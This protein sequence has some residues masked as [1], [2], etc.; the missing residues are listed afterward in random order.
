MDVIDVGSFQRSS[1]PPDAGNPAVLY[2]RSYITTRLAVGVIGMVL[3]T[4]LWAGDGLFMHRFASR[5]SLSAYYHSPMQDV[6][7][8]GLC[9][10]A[11]LLI[12]YMSGQPSTLDFRF[13]TV[14]GLALLVVVFFPTDRGLGDIGCTLGQET[15]CSA[16]ER[17]F[18]E[19]AV[20]HVHAGFAS[21]FIA[22]LAVLCFLF[23]YRKNKY[24][25]KKGQAAFHY[26]CAAAIV[27]SISW[28]LLGTAGVAGDIWKLKP[29]YVGELGSVYAFALS[30]LVKG[31]EIR[32]AF[33]GRATQLRTGAQSRPSPRVRR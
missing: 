6:F 12:T 5:G 33:G 16:V 7:V 15:P 4:I 1:G 2:E 27:V 18:G 25:L 9:A 22:L 19:M 28:V 29:L 17:T 10:I 30:W 31:A 24:E 21:V 32:S 26:G 14:A 8:G 13:S 20:A 11:F 3:P 23:G